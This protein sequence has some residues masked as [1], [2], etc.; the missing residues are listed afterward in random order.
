MVD[1]PV[2]SRLISTKTLDSLVA[3]SKRALRP[4][5]GMVSVI[6]AVLCFMCATGQ[7]VQGSS[8][9]ANVVVFNTS[10]GERDRYCPNSPPG[11]RILQCAA[12]EPALTSA[13]KDGAQPGEERGCFGFRS[14]GDTQ[15]SGDAD[16]ANQN[17][18]GQQRL[19]HL[20]RVLQSAE[21]H[22]V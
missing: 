13:G 19:P 9:R 18:I 8:K 2:P 15:V 4:W 16:V 17:T 20:V 11:G 12:P 22:K 14:C 6:A 7:A 3:L 21:E 5:P 10:L 1:T